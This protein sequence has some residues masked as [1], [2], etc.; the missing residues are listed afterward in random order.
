[1][2]FNRGGRVGFDGGEWVGFDGGG[3]VGSDLMVTVGWQRGQEEILFSLK[4]GNM[5]FQLEEDILRLDRNKRKSKTRVAYITIHILS[6][7][8]YS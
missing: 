3:W 5:S 4:R 7:S 1:M 8:L 2:G 6:L